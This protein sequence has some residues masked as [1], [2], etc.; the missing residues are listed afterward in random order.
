[1]SALLI[2]G[3]GYCGRA[4]AGEA[5]D[6]AVTAT[7]RSVSTL[8]VM[9]RPDRAISINI[10]DRAM[11][12]SGRAMT[13]EVVTLIPFASAAT[14][15]A[16]ASHILVTAP[17][18]A[19]GDPVLNRYADAIAAAPA[20]RWIGYL[21][22]TVVY[23]DQTGAWVD[24]DTPPGPSQSRGQRRLNA[25]QA[26]SRFATHHAVDI[27]RLGGIY[28]PG[29]SAFDDLRAGTARR[30][31]K[32]GH[33]FS[34]IHR[35]D[36]VRAVTTAMRQVREPGCRVLNLV[37]DVPSESAAVMTEAARL[38]GV[39]APPAIAF[40]DAFATMTPMARGFWAEN[41]KVSSQKTQQVLGL[42][43]LYPSF[44]EGLAAIWREESGD[45]PL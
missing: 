8:F 6:F 21:S 12:R 39:P 19:G 36:I 29:R 9:A 37:D 23:G 35:D 34:R 13:N 43:W 7:S 41:R 32:P 5:W 16:A 45:R 30:M 26:W 44:R 15:I 2:F 33:Q 38:M 10:M 3:L 42:R 17:P 27:F 22:S 4:V 24:E 18:D 11:A 31:I 14:A 20:L 28:G 40:T 1:M 25:E